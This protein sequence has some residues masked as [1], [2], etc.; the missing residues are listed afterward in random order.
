M[1]HEEKKLTAMSDNRDYIKLGVFF[2]KYGN[3]KHR[4][5]WVIF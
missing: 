2:L 5:N 1:A 4:K 3:N